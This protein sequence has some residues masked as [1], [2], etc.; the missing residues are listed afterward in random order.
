[1]KRLGMGRRT[2]CCVF[3]LALAVLSGC[4]PHFGPKANYGIT[5][6]C[7]GAGNMDF[8]DQG[9][10]KGLEAAGYKGQVAT[11]TWTVA[12]LMPALDQTVRINAQLRSKLL[13]RYVEDYIDKY[14]GRPVHLVGLSAGTGVAIWALE[15]LEA[16]YN[17]QNVVLLASSLSHDY[18]VSEALRH[19]DGR[20]YNY[21]SSY[22]AVLAVPMKVFGTIDGKFGVDGAGAVGLDSPQ[23][24]EGVVNIRWRREYARYGYAGGHTDGTSPKFVQAVLSQYFIP[25]GRAETDETA[26]ASLAERR[27]R[28]EG[29]D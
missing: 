8:G 28:D 17:V 16:G 24:A 20:I 13:A 26:V 23:G 9:L 14:P 3:G 10:R 2:H 15:N 12:P 19:V 25:Q 11:F 21:Y 1:M 27:S 22:D 7:P 29:R 6:Y 18:D 4:G 5:F